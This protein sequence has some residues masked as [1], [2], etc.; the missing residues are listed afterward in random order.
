MIEER[1]SRVVFPLGSKKG[2]LF[3]ACVLWLFTC[4]KELLM[5]APCLWRA[6]NFTKSSFTSFALI[7]SKQPNSASEEATGSMGTSD[8]W[9]PKAVPTWYFAVAPVFLPRC[10]SPHISIH[11]PCPGIHL[12][13]HSCSVRK[14][15]QSTWSL[16]LGNHCREEG[17]VDSG[18][19][20]LLLIFDRRERTRPCVFI[21]H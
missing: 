21:T 14:P 1:C 5:W 3:S 16:L 9:P 17:H 8:R 12:T 7:L 11:L 6:V 15:F 10:P 19:G 4:H 13:T 2:E 18:L 20:F